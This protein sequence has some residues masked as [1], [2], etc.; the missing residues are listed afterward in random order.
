MTGS[1]GLAA[2]VRPMIA[3]DWPI[4]A[5]I[6]REGI[7]T[8]DATFETEVPTWEE[9]DAGRLAGCRLVAVVDGGVAGWAAL[10]PVS[11]RPVYRG[12]AEPSIYIADGHRGQGL[13]RTLLAALVEA[14]ESEGIWMLQTAIFPENQASIALHESLG[15]RA[16]GTRERIGQHYG[17]WRDTVLME[18]RSTVVGF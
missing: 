16:V 8:R 15:F 11:K 17:H 13:G 10:S 2:H 18:R 14:S 1:S 5:I 7:E 6:Y 3:S 4:V 9:W 12:V